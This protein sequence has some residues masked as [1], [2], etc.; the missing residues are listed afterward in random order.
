M[1]FA[2]LLAHHSPRHFLALH[3]PRRAELEGQV[4]S[5]AIA[6]GLREGRGMRIPESVLDFIVST[7]DWTMSPQHLRARAAGIAEHYVEN[8]RAINFHTATPAEIRAYLVGMGAE[9]GW[10]REYMNMILGTGRSGDEGDVS[11]TSARFD[12]FSGTDGA[13]LT[14]MRSYA[15]EQGLHWAA[16][17]PEILRLGHEAI[18][19]F[20]RLGFSQQSHDRLHQ[21]GFTHH[22]MLH[23]ARFADRTGL[24][25]NRVSEVAADSVRIF[26]GD[27]L[28]EQR[29][30]RE[31][32]D[33]YHA[34][35]PGDTTARERLVE[36]LRRLRREGTGEQQ[37]QA[38]KHLQV[39]GEADRALQAANVTTLQAGTAE[40]TA[41]AVTARAD[42][43]D[44]RVDAI[45]DDL[46][47][48]PAPT[49]QPT[50][51]VMGPR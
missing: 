11:L 22:Q 36:E 16:N 12:A 8:P 45:A 2:G 9:R 23:I 31:M 42:T 18:R 46:N 26:G 21:A 24:D 13:Y 34:A 47:G 51:H 41:G 17:R 14:S 20:A 3:T 43:A 50:Q 7:S 48:P 44:A 30:W 37:N 32:I 38:D 1:S 19:L 35:P 4:R 27:N 29:R 49:R 10:G 25:V 33:A 28:E 15:I 40:A 39:I 5:E 6:A